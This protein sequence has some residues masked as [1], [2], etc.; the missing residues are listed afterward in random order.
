MV[1]RVTRG[2]PGKERFFNTNTS[3]YLSTEKGSEHF[4]V[5]DEGVGSWVLAC[6]KIG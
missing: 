4:F 2:H 6:F 1:L 5:R 3:Y